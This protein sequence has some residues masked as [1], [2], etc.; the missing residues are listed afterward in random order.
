MRTQAA[1]RRRRA[2]IHACVGIPLLNGQGKSGNGNARP[3]R[4]I[5]EA[6]RAKMTAAFP[7]RSKAHL[8][9]DALRIMTKA[10]I[11]DL[12]SEWRRPISCL[13]DTDQPIYENL[14]GA[15]P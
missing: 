6:R 1:G 8:H 14:F 12:W 7:E 9:N 3:Y 2:E 10:L 15:D 4:I 5:Y 13:A 11:S